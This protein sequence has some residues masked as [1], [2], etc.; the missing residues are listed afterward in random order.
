MFTNIQGSFGLKMEAACSSKM[1]VE[2]HQ[3]A[4]HHNSEDSD[5]QHI[6]NG[7]LANM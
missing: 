2:F 7:T 3:A 6:K 4:W 1:L 5:F